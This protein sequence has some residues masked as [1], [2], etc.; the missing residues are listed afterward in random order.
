MTTDK[1]QELTAQI[2]AAIEQLCRETDMAKQSEQYR[3]WLASMS[4]FYN[5]SFGNQILICS[6]RPDATRVA[7]FHAWKDLGRSVKKG[8]KGIRILAQ[9]FANM[10]RRKTATRFGRSASSLSV[11]L[12]CST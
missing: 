4:R 9:L 8:E 5:Y 12:P 6:Q 2:N 11:V 3:D 1:A 7:G 10:M